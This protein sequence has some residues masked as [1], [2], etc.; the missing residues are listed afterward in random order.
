MVLESHVSFLV[1][2]YNQ[3]F[4]LL[5]FKRQRDDSNNSATCM[6]KALPIVL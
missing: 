5:Y 2:E 3:M 1:G 4:I 6:E